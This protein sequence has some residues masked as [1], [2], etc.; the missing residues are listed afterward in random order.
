MSECGPA[1]GLLSVQTGKQ[2]EENEDL[3]ECL[4]KEDAPHYGGDSVVKWQ[5]PW[6][7]NGLDARVF[8]RFLSTKTNMQGD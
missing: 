4:P 7:A 1:G 3:H 8:I 5:T 2:V 6:Q